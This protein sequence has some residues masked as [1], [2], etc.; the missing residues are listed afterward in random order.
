MGHCMDDGNILLGS[1]FEGKLQKDNA[2]NLVSP[3]DRQFHTLNVR[4][5]GVG[6][7][8]RTLEL[9]DLRQYLSRQLIAHYMCAKGLL[10]TIYVNLAFTF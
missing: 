1:F 8:K 2:L 7:E 4:L 9:G 5:R 3:I 10:I 6:E